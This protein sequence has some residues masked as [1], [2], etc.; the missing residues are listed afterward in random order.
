MEVKVEGLSSP[1][2]VISISKQYAFLFHYLTECSRSYWGA[3]KQSSALCPS[4]HKKGDADGRDGSSHNMPHLPS[5]QALTAAGFMLNVDPWKG[6]SNSHQR[7]GSAR[8]LFNIDLKSG[9]RQGGNYDWINSQDVE[10]MVTGRCSKSANILSAIH[11][12]FGLAE[13]LHLSNIWLQHSSSL[14]GIC[15]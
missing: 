11:C 13:I 1:C 2:S 5:Y 7:D 10:K 6:I 4:P 9:C 3:G 15:F 14:L 8:V 12:L